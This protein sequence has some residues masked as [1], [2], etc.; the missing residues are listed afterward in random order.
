MQPG[1]GSHS[2]DDLQASVRNLRDPLGE[3]LENV[4]N[5]NFSV[6][7]RC[8]PLGLPVREADP[9]DGLSVHPCA[10]PLPGWRGTTT[11]RN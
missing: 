3:H 5:Q 7:R 6:T 4:E 10:S 8:A 1:G 11:E 2:L 9:E